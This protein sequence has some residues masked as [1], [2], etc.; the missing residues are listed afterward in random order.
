[1]RVFHEHGKS[2]LG[3]CALSITACLTLACVRRELQSQTS[4]LEPPSGSRTVSQPERLQY[5]G[6]L[7]DNEVAVRF[8][9]ATHLLEDSGIRDIEIDTDQWR[10]GSEVARMTGEW[11][12]CSFHV[13]TGKR[14]DD[15]GWIRVTLHNDSLGYGYQ[16][17]KGSDAKAFQFHLQAPTAWRVSL[18]LPGSQ[19][20]APESR[21]WCYGVRE[22][23]AHELWNLSHEKRTPLL[24]TIKEGQTIALGSYQFGNG[25]FAVA[26]YEKY[27]DPPSF[28]GAFRVTPWKEPVN[29]GT[30]QSTVVT[31]FDLS[32]AQLEVEI[33]GA[34]SGDNVYLVWKD[35]VRR[36]T[37]VALFE[38]R[39]AVVD[40][41]GR[42]TFTSVPYG[43][44]ELEHRPSRRS[45]SLVVSG[46]TSV[47]LP[48]ARE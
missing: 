34:A 28:Y 37:F 39:K 42:A 2:I 48:T 11:L 17:A 6:Y 36:G 13:P 43:E 9:G 44:F 40:R 25:K 8:V 7:A 20:P 46:D 16:V 12:V 24:G 15:L 30:D 33:V 45:L 4:Q 47:T 32:F 10:H 29:T 27:S 14:V 35:A 26:L 19:S 23:G 31:A 38:S 1:M 5:P 41:T 22:Y 3:L 18:A 21:S